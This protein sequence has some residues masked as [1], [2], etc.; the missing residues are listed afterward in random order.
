MKLKIISSLGMIALLLVGCSDEPAKETIEEPEV[1][2]EKP[3]PKTTEVTKETITDIN[4][5]RQIVEDYGV[6]GEDSLTDIDF[7]DGKITA[8]IGFTNTTDIPDYLMAA[9]Y[10]TGAADQLLLYEG[11]TDLTITYT[12]VGTATMNIAQQKDDGY[13]PYFSGE[14]VERQ[15]K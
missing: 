5:V 7:T 10:Y 12:G 9:S 1:A 3:A 11:W 14:E 15:F 6:G 2:V 13:G 4:Q 8:T